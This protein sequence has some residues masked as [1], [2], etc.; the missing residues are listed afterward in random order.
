MAAHH[1]YRLRPDLARG[2]A[3][4]ALCRACLGSG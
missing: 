4:S 3:A 2:W 1:Q